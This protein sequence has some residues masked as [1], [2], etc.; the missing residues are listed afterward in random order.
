MEYF[1]PTPSH[2]FKQKSP[3]RHPF[4]QMFFW[5][6]KLTNSSYVHLKLYDRQATH[7]Q[8]W[9]DTDTGNKMCIKMIFLKYHILPPMAKNFR[10]S[11]VYFT[12]VERSRQNF[13]RNTGLI[14]P[15]SIV[16]NFSRFFKNAL[17]SQPSQP[18]QPLWQPCKCVKEINKLKVPMRH[19]HLDCIKFHQSVSSRLIE[20][21]WWSSP[22]AFL[23]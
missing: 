17:I 12:K 8:P 4:S 1:S 9:R 2:P 23:V 20:V 22:E 11:F 5:N 19:I 13:L 18:F 16:K 3:K 10:D 21:D 6:T 15:P 7:I 14:A